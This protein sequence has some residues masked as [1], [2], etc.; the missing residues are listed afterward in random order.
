[1]TAKPDS[2][3][4]APFCSK[5]GSCDA[6]ERVRAL[7]SELAEVHQR[8]EE[9]HEILDR[10]NAIIRLMALGDCTAQEVRLSDET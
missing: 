6:K 4:A 3:H 7:E 9:F 2:S 5:T 1:M 10:K 8:L